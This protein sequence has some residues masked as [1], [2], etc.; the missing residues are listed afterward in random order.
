MCLLFWWNLCDCSSRSLIGRRAVRRCTELAP[1]GKARPITSWLFSSRGRV[2]GADGNAPRLHYAEYS[3]ASASF[4]K[5]R[6]RRCNA[7]VRRSERITLISARGGLCLHILRLKSRMKLICS[8]KPG[9]MW[10]IP[11]SLIATYFW[12]YT[13]HT[14]AFNFD[15]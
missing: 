4:I 6:D 14:F 12:W 11:G 15:F 7:V 3:L 10:Q 1:D 13:S 5:L 9:K 2:K 8:R